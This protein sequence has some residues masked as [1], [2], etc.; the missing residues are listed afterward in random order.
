MYCHL[1]SHKSKSA[2]AQSVCS[3]RLRAGRSG[4]NFR[5]GLRIFLF[6]TA[7]RP[8]QGHTHPPIQ[9]VP[10]ALS[11][12]V[13]RP[14]QVDHSTPS[15]AEVK[16]C[17]DLMPPLPQYVFMACCLVKHRDFTLQLRIQCT[18]NLIRS[19]LVRTGNYSA[20]G[21]NCQGQLKLVRTV[22]QQKQQQQR[23]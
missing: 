9:W 3:T 5:R 20:A 17:V 2:I 4:F 21:T 1:Y 11:L 6:T 19:W 8:A 14:R 22:Q 23:K 12:G 16:E 18:R 15:S 10:G 13:K 7:S